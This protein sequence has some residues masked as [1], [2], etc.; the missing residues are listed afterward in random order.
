MTLLLRRVPVGMVFADTDINVPIT[1]PP[2]S[3]SI[4]VY[5]WQMSLIWWRPAHWRQG[6]RC[7]K[8]SLGHRQS[9]R[10]ISHSKKIPGDIQCD[11]LIGLVTWTWQKRISTHHPQQILVFLGCGNLL[12][13]PRG[14]WLGDTVCH[15]CARILLMTSCMTTVIQA[16]SISWHP[17]RESLT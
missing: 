17:S 15:A 1:L 11:K 6:R 9:T 10:L 7:T 13:M 16:I 5:Q 14:P 2:P 3:T 12:S 4:C 8:V